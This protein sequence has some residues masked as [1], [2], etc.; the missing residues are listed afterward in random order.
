MTYAYVGSASLPGVSAGL[1]IER[2]LNAAAE[3]VRGPGDFSTALLAAM[4]EWMVLSL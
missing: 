2:A 1:A 4:G 3:E